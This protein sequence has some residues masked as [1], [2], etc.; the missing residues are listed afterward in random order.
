VALP[1]LC[2]QAPP[3][4]GLVFRTPGAP[5]IALAPTV[6]GG[7]ASRSLTHSH[8]AQPSGKRSGS[9]VLRVARCRGWAAA[10]H[11]NHGRR[12]FA[13]NAA[14]ADVST[15]GSSAALTL[16]RAFG[17]LLVGGSVYLALETASELS[18]RA[19]AV[20]R[21]L[22]LAEA[23]APLL[24]RVGP[25][26]L[27]L[28]PWY[29]DTVQATPGARAARVTVTVEGER[30]KC[31]LIV[32]LRRT[33]GA[34]GWGHLLLYQTLGPATWDVV[35]ADA[36]IFQDSDGREVE[37]HGVRD[38][39]LWGSLSGCSEALSS[40]YP[41][42]YLVSQPWTFRSRPSH[43]TAPSVGPGK[44]GASTGRGKYRFEVIVCLFLTPGNTFSK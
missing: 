44:G 18:L 5:S 31:D 9:V 11:G 34:A 40:P 25:P 19:E 33:P 2:A 12:E 35:F 38:G 24:E 13:A 43:V 41:P 28:G 42:S 32:G 29:E 6:P 3:K 20:R 1:M 39:L 23:H 22:P 10:G 15:S 4:V 36:A 26:P 21:L 27:R 14:A 37:R 17:G 7:D 30:A 16:A 8:W